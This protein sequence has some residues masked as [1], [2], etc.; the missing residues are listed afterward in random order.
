MGKKWD[1]FVPGPSYWKACYDALKP[2]GDLIAFGGTRTYDLLVVAI[3]MA[4]FEVRDQLAWMYGQGFPKSLDVAKAVDKAARGVPQGGADP[5]SPN[6]GKFKTQLTEGKRDESDRGQGYGGGPGAF[7]AEAGVTKVEREYVE[8]AEQW[9]GWGTALKPAQEPIVLA[10]KP[11]RGT[12]AAN[13]LEHGTGAMNI[14]GCRIG[15]EV[16]S[17]HNAPPGTLAGGEQ[18]RGSD[19]SS[20]RTHEGRWPANVLL[21]HA[22]GCVLVGSRTVESN[23]L[24][25]SARPAGSQVSGPSGHAGQGDLDERHTK[26]EQV[27][28]WRCVDDCPVRLLD[29]Q[30]GVTVS[31]GGRTANISKGERIYGGGKGLGQDLKPDEVRGDPGYGDRG[32]ASR[33]FYTSKVS[34]KERNAGLPEGVQ[35]L[36]STVKPIE[37]MRYL[38]RLVTPPGGLVVDPFAGSGSTGCA[39]VLEGLEFIGV[40]LDEEDTGV[41]DVANYRIKHWEDQ[42]G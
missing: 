14:D 2:G 33:F 11:F 42:R 8:E 40:E 3:R 37:L 16:I 26:G 35:N 25:P 19:T 34:K 30:S 41:V 9:Q 13:V 4:G 5:T 18:G 12:V 22:D 1:S 39:A 31:T 10:R 38:V 15:N 27:D 28:V 20:Y 17:V 21:S 29:E 24:Y 23:G 36:H 6:H 32:G 7:M